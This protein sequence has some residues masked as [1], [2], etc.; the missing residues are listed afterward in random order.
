MPTSVSQSRILSTLFR[1]SIAPRD[2]KS[3]ITPVG[4]HCRN[5]GGL[6]DIGLGHRQGETEV[7]RKAD[8][9]QPGRYFAEKVR[10]TRHSLPGPDIQDPFPKDRCVHQHLTLQ[11]AHESR[12]CGNHLLEGG[13]RHVRGHRRSHRAQGV[14][15]P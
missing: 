11:S 12:R 7:F 14:V 5:A 1:H 8:D 10:D 6:A 4:M 2:L 3:S 13:V 9:L 15:R